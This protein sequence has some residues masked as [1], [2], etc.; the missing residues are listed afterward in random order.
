MTPRALSVAEVHAAVRR[1]LDARFLRIALG[2]GAV[3]VVA[4][5]LLGWLLVPGG[6]ADR[7]TAVPLL[8]DLAALV[9]AVAAGVRWFRVRKAHLDASTIGATMERVSG[10]ADGLVRGSM[11]LARDLPSGVS[12]SLVARG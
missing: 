9:V 10:L 1:L 7:P 5:L 6:A 3:V 12:R 11:E 2:W 4:T 8:I